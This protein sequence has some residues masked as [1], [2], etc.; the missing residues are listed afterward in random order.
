MTRSPGSR[1]TTTF[2]LCAN[3]NKKS[4]TVNIAKPG[5]REI[6]CQLTED[7]E[8]FMENY[9]VGDLKRF[10]STTSGVLKKINPDII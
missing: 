7:V 9:E 1:R 2:Y 4:V 6:I 8:V 10:G 5:G 3:R